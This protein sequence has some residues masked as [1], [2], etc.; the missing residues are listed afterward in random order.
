MGVF[1]GIRALLS[2]CEQVSDTPIYLQKRDFPLNSCSLFVRFVS[3]EAKKIGFVRLR[4][5]MLN[6]RAKII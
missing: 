2:V 5:R 1:W 4:R 3:P 6:T